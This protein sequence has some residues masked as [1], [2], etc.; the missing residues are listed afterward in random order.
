MGDNVQ[1]ANE[2]VNVLL[3]MFAVKNTGE[4]YG[5]TYKLSSNAGVYIFVL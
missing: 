5:E 4:N 3:C 2:E 1:G